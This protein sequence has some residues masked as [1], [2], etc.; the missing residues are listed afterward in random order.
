MTTL[1]DHLDL[2]SLFD[3]Y[4]RS[5]K[6]RELLSH[7]IGI[8]KC[9]RGGLRMAER[10]RLEFDPRADY[11]YR[12]ERRLI[13]AYL[14]DRW[15]GRFAPAGALRSVA[16]ELLKWFDQA[17]PTAVDY[18][19]VEYSQ[20]GGL[21]PICTALAGHARRM[22]PIPAWEPLRSAWAAEQTG[23]ATELGEDVATF[24]DHLPG[25]QNWEAGFQ[26]RLPWFGYLGA[27]SEEELRYR[28]AFFFGYANL[29]TTTNAYRGGGA[30]N[31]A[32]V[33]Q[34]TPTSMMLDYAAAFAKGEYFTAPGFFVLG[35][36]DQEPQDRSRYTSV[37]EVNG[38]LT[39]QRAPYY[40][41]S[42][43]AY[44]KWF[45][46]PETVVEPYE[47]T[48]RA[49]Q[50]TRRWLE[51]RPERLQRALHLFRNLISTPASTPV[52]LEMIESPKKQLA[53][54]DTTLLD[55][56][57]RAELEETAMGELSKLTDLDGAAIAL[58]LLVAGKAYLG[59]E[60]T[61]VPRSP[62][63]APETPNKI[64]DTIGP[65]PDELR[66]HGER[67]LAYL[68][69][70]L[71]V[72]FAGA[73]GTG[74]TTLAQFVG[75][76]WDRNLESL[77]LHFPIDDA[78]LTTVGNSAWSPFHTIG[79]LMPMADGTF[80]SHPGIFVDPS[81]TG[82]N[83]WRLLD[84]ALV[85][86]E[87]NRSDLDRCIG[88]LYPLLSGSVRRVSPAGLPG[89]A[90]IEASARFR[91]IA[92][93]NDANLDDIVF[94]IS[95]GLARRFQ[96]IEL[97]G[98]S[99]DDVLAF[100]GLDGDGKSADPLGAAAYDAVANLFEVAREAKLLRKDEDDDRLPFGVAYF[101]LVKEW[102]AK[103]LT[104]PESTPP[105]QARELVAASLRPLG[106]SR[107]WEDALRRFL[108]KP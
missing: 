2:E 29:W 28:Q 69:A 41:A 43:R 79:G 11:W 5:D 99:R 37:L 23:L 6:L 4:D 48:A 65:L 39:L 42:S 13:V 68:K 31:F 75:Y 20:V 86:D 19:G 108:A 9:I 102:I 91:V 104:L 80:H 60:D 61:S 66:P 14:A 18:S 34:N 67:A 26:K 45:D 10:H 16:L 95:E 76:A 40:L 92:T 27:R 17:R 44:S 90:C 1:T 49:G 70:G 46:I 53:V 8:L 105:E 96:R 3:L 55:D 57:F 100:L 35:K 21:S 107:T 32:P 93:I 88:E 74:K 62:V 47:L 73:P 81:S 15:T 83:V 89:V 30:R 77:P 106:R 84:R 7:N 64:G 22:A 71:H 36:G 51:E 94:P 54:A 101:A 50:I 98:G 85:L 58:H 63:A 72:L 56:A 33:I 24:L 38:F 103:R 59:L 87:M 52:A 25:E 78:P 97:R 12:P 82:S